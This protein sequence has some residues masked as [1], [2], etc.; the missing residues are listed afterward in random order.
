VVSLDDDDPDSPGRQSR[1]TVNLAQL[2]DHARAAL[3]AE[4]PGG[5]K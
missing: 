1:R 2:I 5:G 3:L 4:Q